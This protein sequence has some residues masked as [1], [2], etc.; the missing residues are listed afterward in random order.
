MIDKLLEKDVNV[1]LSNSESK[2]ARKLFSGKLMQVN[3]I[4]VTRTI[5]RKASTNKSYKSDKKELFKKY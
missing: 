5:Q 3:S 2:E 1:M 4:P